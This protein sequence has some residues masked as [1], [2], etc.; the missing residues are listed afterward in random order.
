MK[1]KTTGQLIRERRKKLS[2][3]QSDL[4][5]SLGVGIQTIS[6]IER[7]IAGVPP[8]RVKKLAKCLD[9]ELESIVSVILTDIRKDLLNKV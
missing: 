7:G 3:A 9:V 8:R 2:L 1:F 4:A 6:N 5:K